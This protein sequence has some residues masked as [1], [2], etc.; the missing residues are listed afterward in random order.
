MKTATVAASAFAE[1]V[2]KVPWTRA[3][4]DPVRFM[5]V[6]RRWA[7]SSCC[8]EKGGSTRR[9]Q[10]P[11]AGRRATSRRL[12]RNPSYGSPRDTRE[13][14]AARADPTPCL[15]DGEASSGS[16]W[17]G[18]RTWAR[19]HAIALDQL[20]PSDDPPERA[21]VS[22]ASLRGSRPLTSLSRR[23]TSASKLAAKQRPAVR[24][25]VSIPDGH[26]CLWREH[27][28]AQASD[29]PPRRGPITPFSKRRIAARH[30][31]FR[32]SWHHLALG[33]TPSSDA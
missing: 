23:S 9:P 33:R 11:P 18:R 4:V 7:K 5:C 1:V 10:A 21:G 32:V 17:R 14:I 15:P 26:D 12:P 16:P 25:P 27:C 29:A 13:T 31:P 6:T 8:P 24:C 19:C 3:A 28:W 2:P 22:A 30:R 20:R